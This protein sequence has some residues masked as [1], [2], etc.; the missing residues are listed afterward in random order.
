MLCRTICGEGSPGPGSSRGVPRSIV[1][2]SQGC[3]DGEGPWPGLRPLIP[4]LPW[5]SCVVRT[6]AGRPK[7]LRR[8]S[9]APAVQPRGRG[10]D[11][12]GGG[13]ETVRL[14]STAG[15]IY[16]L[17]SDT[18]WSFFF[19]GRVAE[20]QRP[21][22]QRP[23]ALLDPRIFF[24][25]YN[26]I[27]MTRSPLGSVPSKAGRVFKQDRTELAPKDKKNGTRLTAAR[28]PSSSFESDTDV[29]CQTAPGASPPPSQISPLW[30]LHLF[31]QVV[32]FH[33]GSRAIGWWGGRLTSNSLQVTTTHFKSAGLGCATINGDAS[34]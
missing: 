31:S 16:M 7:G 5:N 11:L 23:H 12:D 10:E 22:D 4:R 21:K 13:E 30:I 1:R 2:G 14:A 8:C 17:T 27:L 33:E 6:N 15:G 34:F 9:E 20:D 29:P 25:R 3:T 24:T 26:Q 32:Q 19:F 18:T 28:L